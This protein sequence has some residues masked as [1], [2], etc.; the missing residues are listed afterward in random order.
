M[1]IRPGSDADLPTLVAALGQ[2]H[3]F[4]MGC[5]SSAASARQLRPVELRPRCL[6]ARSYPGGEALDPID[7]RLKADGMEQVEGVLRPG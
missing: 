6:L 3:F 2:R 1:E 4:T 5:R 7:E